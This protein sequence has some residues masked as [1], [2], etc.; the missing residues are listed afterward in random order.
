MATTPAE[1][2]Q[3]TKG[4]RREKPST[5]GQTGS[6][7]FADLVRAHYEWERSGACDG[8]LERRYRR[9]LEEFQKCEGNLQHAYWATRRPSAVAL[10]IKP[11][12][13]IA[14]L[15]SDHDA[16]IR[17]H[18]LTDWLARERSIADLLHHSD[19]L[20]IKVSEVLRGTAERIAMQWLY[21]VQ[22]HLLGF[23]ERT[24]G[25][26]SDKEL[27]KVV[28][29]Q[30]RELLE[31]E[32]YYVRAGEQAARISY[33]WGM[34]IGV[35]T[36]GLLALALAAVLWS[37]GWFE[38]PHTRAVETFFICY[39]AGGLGAIVSVLMRMSSKFRVDYEVGRATIRR[40]GSFRP[41]IGA[42]FGIA[43]YFLLKSGIPQVQLPKDKATTF[44]FFG[45]VAFLSG[46]NERWANVLFGKA[47]HT[48]AA[49]LGESCGEPKSRI[50]P[51]A[52]GDE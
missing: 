34:M 47:E 46:F 4:E 51:D 29:S 14:S 48:I 36:T 52:E 39:M 31:I 15:R 18:R 3:A 5:T 12:A 42:V 17:L 19:T 44:F 50:R 37:T 35:V 7:L 13:R 8:E 26:A 9:N 33:F 38:Q 11:R 40:L 30:T 23:I 10:T 49:S 20:A 6:I 41:F 25:R 27:G 2:E 45:V 22:S 21:S 24:H 32:R 1:L 16:T 28:E 43:L